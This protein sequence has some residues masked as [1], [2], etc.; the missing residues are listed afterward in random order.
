MRIDDGAHVSFT[1]AAVNPEATLSDG[2]NVAWNT[3]T[4]PVAKVT[5]VVIEI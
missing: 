5:L 1:A 4:S 3:L 2:A